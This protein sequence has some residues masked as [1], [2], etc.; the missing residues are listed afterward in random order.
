VLKN[1]A[2]NLF[3]NMTSYIDLVIKIK[4]AQKARKEIMKTEY[5]KMKEAI[6]AILSKRGF[7]G[8]FEIKG[9]SYKKY[10][11]INLSG[12]KPITNVKI[13]SKPSI[14]VYAGYKEIK[15]VRNGGVLILSTNKG[16]LT[17]E[18]AK[19]LGVGGQL[20]ITVS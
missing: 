19:K 4:N 16:I 20:L 8:G 18:Q 1:Q 6:V 5:S 12:K 3:K 9:R 13:L 14:K 7:I 11:E 15:P 17:G 10:I 2:G